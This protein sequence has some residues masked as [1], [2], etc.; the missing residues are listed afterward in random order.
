MSWLQTVEMIRIFKKNYEAKC[1]WEYA[2]QEVLICT[3]WGKNP[4]VQVIL[5]PY[6][7][8]CFLAS[9]IPELDRKLTVSFS[10]TFKGL[11]NVPRYTSS[12]LAFSMNAIDHIN[13]VFRK[14]ANSLMRRVTA[15][16]KSI[17]T[18]IVNNDEYNQSPLIDKWE[19]TL[20]V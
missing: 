2:G 19:S 6:L 5:L 3:Y 9:F 7:R 12:R 14:F 4:T 20:Y 18:T 10:D 11:I 15:S 16:C 13:V 8:M 1:C 17:V